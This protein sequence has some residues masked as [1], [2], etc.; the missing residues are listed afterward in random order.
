MDGAELYTL[1]WENSKLNRATIVGFRRQIEEHTRTALPGMPALQYPADDVPLPRPRD[2]LARR[3]LERRSVR[4][5]RDEPVTRRQLGSLFS[6]FA[7]S[8]SGSRAFASA[9]ATYPLEVYCLVNRARGELDRTVVYY[10]HDNHSLAVVGRL[11]EWESYAD[12]VN[13]EPLSGI[14]QLVFV[15]VVFP[16][17]VTS[18]YGERGGRFQLIEVGHAAQNLAL[19]LVQERMVGCEAGGLL[20]DRVRSLLGLEGTTAQIALGYACG[21]GQ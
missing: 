20:D 21:L 17:R 1:F 9:G 12:A 8:T 6:A 4:A 5:F 11:P 15:F 16:E 3:M 14:P 2:R 7:S 19:R 10:N 18:K 13:L